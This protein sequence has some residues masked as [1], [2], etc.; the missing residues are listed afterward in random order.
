MAWA[1][2]ISC[3]VAGGKRQGAGYIGCVGH[4]WGQS[5][6]VEHIGVAWAW[7]AENC[8]GHP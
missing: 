7:I 8:E 6:Y 3:A 4:K 1:Y 5:N 2:V